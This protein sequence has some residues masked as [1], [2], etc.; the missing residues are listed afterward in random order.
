MITAGR[1]VIG[2]SYTVAAL[3]DSP[4]A[5]ADKTQMSSAAQE[6][7]NLRY[8]WQ[9]CEVLLAANFTG[10]DLFVTLT[11][12]E[13][14]L[15]PTR[16]AAVERM[17]KFIAKLRSARKLR[18]EPTKYIYVT[19]QLSSEGGRLHHHMVLNGTGDDY[20]TIRSLWEWGEVEIKPL[21]VGGNDDGYEVVAKYLT[22]EPRECGKADV[23]ART[24]TPSLGLIRPKPE[25]SNMADNETI[26]APP[27]AY[28]LCAPA[29]SR[30]EFGE[31]VYIKY[32][33]PLIKEEQSLRRP[34]RRKKKKRV[35]P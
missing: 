11:Y 17:K 22:K 29:P 5:R 13:A 26:T 28:I 12:D 21:E 25:V 8:S 15:P 35:Q 27:G 30:N 7:I 9:K 24:W 1:L 10:K 33:L 32:L 4:K 16:A 31:F 6:L 14:N 3:Q 34:Q 19:E 18:G 23:G 2:V 20:D